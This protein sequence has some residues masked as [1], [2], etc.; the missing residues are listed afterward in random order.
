[1]L[2]SLSTW[3]KCNIILLFRLSEGYRTSL[4]SV[5][6]VGLNAAKLSESSNKKSLNH[7]VVYKHD[8]SIPYNAGVN[9]EIITTFS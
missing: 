7:S 1:M 2:F 4:P 9:F 5:S 6:R 3:V 8:K